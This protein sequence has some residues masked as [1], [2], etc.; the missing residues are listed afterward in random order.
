MS[1]SCVT[2]GMRGWPAVVW[3][4]LRTGFS[5]PFLAARESLPPFAGSTPDF[6]LLLSLHC[7]YYSVIDSRDSLFI[8]RVAE[9][10]GAPC[11]LLPLCHSPPP[12]QFAR[13]LIPGESQLVLN[14]SPSDPKYF[15]SQ[16][17]QIHIFI[18]SLIMVCFLLF[19]ITFHRLK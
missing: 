12:D 9:F 6:Y 15:L 7:Y 8:S 2:T 17:L 11:Y 3:I 4:L 16:R 13:T 5:L 14:P 1:P 10:G 19:H 18:C